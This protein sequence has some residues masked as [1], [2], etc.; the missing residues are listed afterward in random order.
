MN[1]IVIGA[2]PNGLVAAF[3]LARA[4]RRPIVLEQSDAIGGGARTAEIHPGFRAPIFS[5]ELLLNEGVAADMRLSAHGLR[6]IDGEMDTCAPALDGPPLLLFREAARTAEAMRAR[7]AHDAERWPH[8]RETMTRAAGVIAPL[9]TTSPLALSPGASDI[10]A[11]LKTRHRLR[12]IGE[13]GRHLLRWIPMPVFDFAHEWFADDH[14][15]A[16]VAAPSL[17]GTMLAPR[18][19]GSTLLLF[20]REAQ[21]LR[22]GGGHRSVEGGPGAAMR[23]MAAAATAAGAEVRTGVSVERVLTRQGRVIGLVAA[24]KELPTDLVISTADPRTT[25][26]ALLDRDALPADLVARVSTYRASGTMAK[27]N[28]ALDSLP[29]FTAVHDQQLLTGRIHL[30]AP[31]MDSLERA[32]DAVKYGDI[33]PRPWLEVR[34]PSI[35]D[36]SLAPAG[37]HVASIY[38]HNAPYAGPR[39][40]GTSARDELL[41]RTLAVLDDYA[42]GTS[43]LV[44]AADAK[45]PA[46]LEASLRASGGHIFHGELSPDQLLSLRPVFGIGQYQTP[47]DGLYLGSAGTHPG[48]FLTGMSGRLAA[49]AALGH[50]Q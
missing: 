4:G 19:A 44:R 22:A 33:S 50:R 31:D 36:R 38:V 27:V 2:G 11:L 23:A 35:A 30:G 14:L 43:G 40:A 24:G 10:W 49:R 37:K 45:M 48:G 16:V 46:D 21:A 13:D 47:I 3:Y 5:H 17:T 28:L 29:R 6:G 26:L 39:G 25:L 34:I 20:L 18:S 42:P 8:Y 41:K 1:P 9:L 32:F 7:N 15:R 12:H